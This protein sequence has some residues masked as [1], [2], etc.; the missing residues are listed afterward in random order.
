MVRT[1]TPPSGL[2]SRPSILTDKAAERD[3]DA[4]G[5]QPREHSKV[6]ERNPASAHTTREQPAAA[7]AHAP[8][9]APAHAITAALSLG[10][11]AERERD[12]L[13]PR[14]RNSSLD[15]L[16]TAQPTTT[17]AEEEAPPPPVLSLPNAE[18]KGLL[19]KWRPESRAIQV[20]WI[21]AAWNFCKLTEYHVFIRYKRLSLLPV[22]CPVMLFLP[23]D[24]IKRRNSELS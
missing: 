19:I 13:Q 11:E 10:R 8:A 15:T 3:I 21:C 5:K 14:E 23:Y 6:G 18:V 7:P 16:L 2:R 24:V 17:R 22:S 4:F 1:I 20:F 12:H 9:A